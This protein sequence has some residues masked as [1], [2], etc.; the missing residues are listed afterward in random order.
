MKTDVSRVMIIVFDGLRP[1][2]VHSELMPS[3][4]E[5]SGVL[6]VLV[7]LILYPGMRWLQFC[8]LSFSSTFAE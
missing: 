7:I 5:S 8:S 6:L 3:L 4:Y 1:D 2:F